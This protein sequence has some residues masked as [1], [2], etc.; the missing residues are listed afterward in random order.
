LGVGCA[1]KWRTGTVRRGFRCRPTASWAR[2]DSN[3]G[4][5]DYEPAPGVSRGVV[6]SADLALVLKIRHS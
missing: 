5:T 3:Q 2:L 6:A 1:F 4:P